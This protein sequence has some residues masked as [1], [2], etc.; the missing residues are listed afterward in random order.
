MVT[1]WVMKV[2]VDQVIDMVAMWHSFVSAIWAV[3]VSGFMAATLM[4]RGTT[5]RVLCA[6]VDA[7]LVNVVA[8]R[9]MKVAIM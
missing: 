6:D 3:H 1:V 9:M 8:V 2:T 7:V 5:V 4:V